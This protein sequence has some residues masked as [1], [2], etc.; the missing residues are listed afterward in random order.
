MRRQ[1]PEPLDLPGL[2]PDL[3]PIPQ[4]DGPRPLAQIAYTDTYAEAMS[5]LRALMAANELSER[6]LKV[7]E[8]IIGINPAHY[9]CWGFRLR[10]LFAVAKGGAQVESTDGSTTTST[11]AQ[12]SEAQKSYELNWLQWEIEYLNRVAVQHEKNYQIWHHRQMVM[13]RVGELLAEQKDKVKEMIRSEHA[14]TAKMFDLD[15]KNYHVWS[16]RQWL[17]RRFKLF[18]DPSELSYIE[19]L[20]SRD[21]R[22]NSAWNHRFFV[23]FGSAVRPTQEV[24]DREVDYTQNAIYLAPQNPSP[25]NYLRGILAQ[26]GT[27]LSTL[28]SFCLTFAPISTTSS[29]ND[30]TSSH[31][32][33]LLAEI[34]AEKAKLAR[35]GEFQKE[36]EEN[37]KNAVRALE[38]LAERYDPIRANY[39]D[40][41]KREVLA[42]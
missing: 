13:D 11:L 6:T 37:K 4:D 39:W 34:Y 28:L 1:P 42:V 32:L 30:V 36:R 35:N 7:T 41:R 15:S 22:N 23:I 19:E 5:Y 38:L 29:T 16:Y 21:V 17:V 18:S 8:Y 40:W 14:F 12:I 31:A 24:V 27:P 9:T 26:T 2:L 10:A 3:L 20:L 33:D 25:W